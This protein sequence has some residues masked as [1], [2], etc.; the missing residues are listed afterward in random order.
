MLAF[1]AFFSWF[2]D[3]QAFDFGSG[4]NA[5]RDRSNPRLVKITLQLNGV[6]PTDKSNL[7]ITQ[8]ETAIVQQAIVNNLDICLSTTATTCGQTVEHV[9]WAVERR[10]NPQVDNEYL[11]DTQVANFDSNGIILT[12]IP[13]DLTL[14]DYVITILIEDQINI[15]VG[16]KVLLRMYPDRESN[17]GNKDLTTLTAVLGSG[18]RDTLPLGTVFGTPQTLLVRLNAADT[19][20]FMDNSKGVPAGAVGILVP[21]PQ[22]GSAISIPTLSYEIDPI[23]NPATPGS[24]PLIVDWDAKTCSVNCAEANAQSLDTNRATAAGYQTKSTLTP[25]AKSISFTNVS[26]TGGPYAIIASYLPEGTGFSCAIGEATD[27]GTLVQLSGGKDP[28]TGD[29]NCFIATAAY[30]T[31]MDPHI[32]VLRWFRDRYLLQSAWG[33]SFVRFY[34]KNSPPV[35]KWISEHEWARTLTRG[36]LWTPILIIKAYKDHQLL[37]IM[38][39]LAVSAMIIRRLRRTAV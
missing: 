24:C 18:V 11:S 5:V 27:A 2:S 34:Y 36:A 10:P 23:A 8:E 22:D 16:T 9:R 33:K 1:I 32:D 31:A 4:S 25:A 20:T 37:T 38:L 30:G 14:S 28:K 3:A 35:A 17:N 12:P 21:K 19:V 15:G 39:L 26:I 13:T 7:G 6:N 29:P